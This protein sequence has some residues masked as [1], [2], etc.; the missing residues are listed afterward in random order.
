[1]NTTSETAQQTQTNNWKNQLSAYL[2]GHGILW[3]RNWSH[4]PSKPEMSWS[5]FHSPNGQAANA[6]EDQMNRLLIIPTMPEMATTA[7]TPAAASQHP[8]SSA[9]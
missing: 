1:L 2:F 5:K 7:T 4:L 6:N 3:Q 9:A 8:T